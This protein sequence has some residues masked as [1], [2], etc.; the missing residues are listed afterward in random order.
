MC[1]NK[2][3]GQQSSKSKNKLSFESIDTPAASILKSSETETVISPVEHQ[4]SDP[5]SV[6][7][8]SDA[9]DLQVSKIILPKR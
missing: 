5:E 6:E 1:V 4:A 2:G 7:N 9:V 3:V 8:G